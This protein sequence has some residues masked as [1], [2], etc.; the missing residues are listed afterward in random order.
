M[1]YMQQNLDLEEVSGLLSDPC[2]RVLR[3]A[4]KFDGILSVVS[5]KCFILDLLEHA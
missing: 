4:C 1:T 5:C 3:C 2:T